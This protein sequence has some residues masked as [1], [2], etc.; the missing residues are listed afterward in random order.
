MKRTIA[1]IATTTACFVGLFILVTTSTP[2][3]YPEPEPLTHQTIPP[4]HAHYLMST[5]DH[6]TL[7]DVRTSTEFAELHIPGATLIPY[8]KLESR[9]TELPTDLDTPIFIYCNSGN[10]SHYAA[11]FLTTLGYKNVYDFGGIIDWP[12][13]TASL[14]ALH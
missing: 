10:R 7:L 2:D 12:F 3:I 5:L 14:L 6:F 1:I 11:Q 4:E 13:E 9:I 8:S